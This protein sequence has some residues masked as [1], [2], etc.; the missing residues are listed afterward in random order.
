M[1]TSETTVD[2]TI[3][4]LVCIEIPCFFSY[5]HQIELIVQI[6]CD[7]ICNLKYYTCTCEK[8]FT[9]QYQIACHSYV[10][11]M[12]SD[13]SLSKLIYTLY[14]QE[15]QQFSSDKKTCQ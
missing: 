3:K 6:S 8:I 15:S 5:K 4:V 10:Q 13:D 9:L 11:M 7:L 1:C 2:Q 12:F 14:V